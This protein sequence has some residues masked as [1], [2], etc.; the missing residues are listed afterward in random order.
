M[1][2]LMPLRRPAAHAAPLL[3]PV[4]VLA[5]LVLVGCGGGGGGGDSAVA[6][7]PDGTV[8]GL[9]SSAS[10][11]KQCAVPRPG[12]GD[13]PGS[14]ATEKA[15]LRSW[16]DETYLWYQDVRNLPAI[17][18][19]A[20]AYATPLSY[21]AALKTPLLTASGKLKDGFHFT[22]DTPT[23]VALS[24]T[25]VSY[26]YG[27][28]I[29]LLAA[30]PPRSAVVAFT[31]PGTPAAAAGIA[32]GAAILTVDGV[33][34][35]TGS[36]VPTLNAGLFP[37]AVGSHTFVIRDQGAA[38]TR[39]VTLNA[40]S[41]TSVPVQ[42]TRAL[43]PPHANVGYLL[44]NDHVATAEAQLVAAINTL[45]AAS[46]TDL[47]LDMRYN[48]GG[49][50]DIAAQL[51]YMIAGP[52]NTN[53]KF[54]ERL[55]FNDRNPFNRS[56]AQSTTNFHSTGRGFSV[57]AG[58]PL[59]F[60]GLSRVYVLTSADTCSASE[61]VVNGLRGAGVTVHLVG[62]T[63]CG[64]PYGFYPQDNCN[65]TYFA[66]QFQGVNNAGFGDYSDGFTPTCAVSD[67]F[68]RPL[69]DPAEN[70]LEVALGLRSTGVCV[71]PASAG[72][73]PGGQAKALSAARSSADTAARPVLVRNV[74]R[75]NRIYRALP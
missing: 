16:I 60:L 11:A 1:P 68:T 14:L 38:A 55:S 56:T 17:T 42:N 4:L 30:K 44:F 40:G 8:T 64:K 6:G 41:I 23:W 5:A 25:G 71:T 10:L 20:S 69:G 48:G 49:Y 58:T 21:F 51:A 28:E 72:I 32:R 45:Q 29:A 46:V 33:D 26:G 57:A 47:V 9:P 62:G 13:Q 39:T 18:L 53:G 63:T 67:D 19:D 43:P 70:M 74:F 59:P 2:D 52:D 3:A 22:Y 15:F 31:D 37:K 34:F 50:L 7:S 75:E 65:T 61:S 27:F 73:N 36:D 24:Q 66:I 35:A 54:F 12:S